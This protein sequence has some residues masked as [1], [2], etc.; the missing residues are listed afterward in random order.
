MER[1]AEHVLRGGRDL[2]MCMYA[3]MCRVLVHIMYFEVYEN[4]RRFAPRAASAARYARSQEQLNQMRM[5]ESHREVHSF[6][7]KL[8]TW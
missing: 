5:T 2:S 4:P 8:R 1:Y 3:L 7:C 6:R